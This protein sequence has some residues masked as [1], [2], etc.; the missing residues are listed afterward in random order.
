MRYNCENNLITIPLHEFVTSARRGIY[1]VPTHDEDEPSPCKISDAYIKKFCEQIQT[2]SLTLP[3]EYDSHSFVIECKV[4]EDSEGALCFFT[5]LDAT[6]ERAEEKAQRRGESYIAAL[7]Y[8]NQKCDTSVAINYF[9]INKLTGEY[10]KE[11]EI[12]EKKKLLKFFVKCQSSV[13][14]YAG[15]EINRV[16]VRL[17]SLSK[18]KFPYQ[19]V[20]EGQDDFVR[21]TY[22]AISRASVLFATAPTGT[23]KTISAL[24]PALKAIGDG[25]C[26][27]VFY[28]TPKET[29]GRAAVECI[30]LLA[31]KGAQIRAIRL[32]AKEKLCKNGLVCRKRKNLCESSKEN[33]ISYAV[34]SLYEKNLSVVEYQDLSSHAEEYKVCPYELALAYAEL[35]DAIICDFNYL[36]DYDAYI[37]R[38]FSEKGSYA[39]LI[40]EA[41]NL[42]QRAREMYSAELS[43]EDLTRIATSEL[44][45]PHSCAKNTAERAVE[46]FASS[47]M[48]YVKEDIREDE[49]G[50]KVSATHINEI[51][52]SLF[53][54]IEEV[55][56]SLTNEITLNFSAKDEN[57]DARA[58]FLRSH[59]QKIKKYLRVMESFD[60]G[61]EMFIFYKNG[62][63]STKLFCIDTG[64]EIAKRISL[65]KA[66][67]FFSATLTPL[68]Y[69][70]SLLGAESSRN[71]LLLPSPFCEENLCVRIMDK[72][73]TRYSQRAKTLDAVVKVI[74][75]TVSAKRG[76]YMIFSPSF[77]YSE[78]IANAFRQKYPK[79][80]VLVQKRD[81]TQKQKKAFLDEFTKK[82]SSYLIGFCVM[83]GSYSEGIDLAGEALIGT[84]IIGIGMPPITYEREAMA[85]YFDEKYEEGKL[86]AY[87]Y[88]G[89]NRVLQA[90]GRVLRR[91]DDRGVI[92]LVDDRFDDP[93]YKKLIPSLWHGMKFIDTPKELNADILQFWSEGEKNSK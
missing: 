89:I 4:W 77:E 24:F 41:H 39:F 31:E 34:I 73:G 81:F 61:Y 23:G 84:V 1:A 13:A 71:T 90:A 70:Q 33:K 2:H 50:D 46:L 14:L 82:N 49:N 65:G 19:S 30:Q 28:L 29:T 80:N 60:V 42:P 35:C 64:K 79:I 59:L 51:P 47:L 20:R 52:I 48:P 75:A 53:S 93:I 83:G 69:Y 67:V 9:F 66:A 5:E 56:E 57:R 7:A 85:K 22:R 40:D 58:V 27:K 74:A 37:R 26:D 21:G 15:P 86:F 92:V 44:L 63:I 76:N 36:F 68:Y 62:E 32:S 54:V 6:K 91:E 3:F 25:R 55:A 43:L 87:I 18:M 8:L 11:T 38:F 10:K 12:A 16:T 88:P 45:T 78:A 72:I 17:P